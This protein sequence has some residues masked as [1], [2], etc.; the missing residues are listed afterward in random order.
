MLDELGNEIPVHTEPV[1]KEVHV[2][3]PDVATPEH[4]EAVTDPVKARLEDVMHE[5]HRVHERLDNITEKLHERVHEV[6]EPVAPPVEEKAEEAVP[7]AVTLDIDD[8]EAKDSH[9]QGKKKAEKPNKRRGL[10]R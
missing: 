1:I 2:S 3:P 5:L 10:R 8:K 7:D 9:P 6:P 4:L